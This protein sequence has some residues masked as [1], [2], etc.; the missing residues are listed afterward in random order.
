MCHFMVTESFSP[1]WINIAQYDHFDSEWCLW[2]TGAVS[3]G[4]EVGWWWDVNTGSCAL[5]CSLRTCCSFLAEPCACWTV[6]IWLFPDVCALL[7]PLYLSPFAF[8]SHRSLPRFNLF[9]T[10]SP[11]PATRRTWAKINWTEQKPKWMNR[12]F[13]KCLSEQSV[14]KIQWHSCGA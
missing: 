8:I 13:L 12:L 2:S 11:H 14:Y 3:H 5:T 6:L 10:S 9:C 7:F 4:E 1:C